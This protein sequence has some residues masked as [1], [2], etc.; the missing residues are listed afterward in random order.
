MNTLERMAIGL[1]LIVVGTVAAYRYVLSDEQRAV[2]RELA[3]DVRNA[4]REVVDVVSPLVSDGP[5]KSDEE[6]AARANR[7]RTATMWRGLGY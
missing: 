6:A 4:T 5:T 7:E 2:A 3:D 1:G